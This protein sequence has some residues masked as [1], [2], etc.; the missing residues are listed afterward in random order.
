MRDPEDIRFV[1]ANRLMATGAMVGKDR[2]VGRVTWAK[3]TLSQVNAQK[4]GVGVLRWI[5][6]L[7]AHEVDMGNNI[8]S[9]DID[10]SIGQD[11]ATCTIKVAN[12][13]GTTSQPEGLDTLGRPGFLTP[14][15]GESI[16]NYT[17]IFNSYLNNVAGGDITQE[18][19]NPYPTDWGYS[20]NMYRD[21]FIPNTVIRTYQGYGSDNFDEDGNEKYVHDPAS[22]GWVHPKND[23][24]LYLTGVWLIDKATFD[25]QGNMTLECRDLGKLLIEQ[26]IYPPMI[27]ISRYPLI[28]CPA[29]GASGQHESIGRNVA[30]YHS[31]SVD[32]WYG[33]NAAVFGHRGTDAFDGSPGSFWLSVGNGSPNDYY[34]YEWVQASTSGK[35]NE[36]VLNCKGNNYLIYVSVYEN[37]A[38]QG[39][40]TI[41]YQPRPPGFPNQ[42]NIKFVKQVTTGSKEKITIPLPRTYKA[43]FVRVTFTNLQDLGF[44]GYPYRAGLRDFVVRNHVGNTYKP[45]APDGSVGKEGIRYI[46]DWSEPIKELCAW[47]G[48]TWRDATPNAPDPLFGRSTAGK[49]LQVWG[50]FEDIGAGPIVCTPGTYFTAK[51]FMQGIRQIVDFIGGIFFVDEYGGANFRLPNIWTGGN[52]ITDPQSHFLD[53]AIDGHPIEFHENA[54]LLEYQLVLDDSQ[55]RSEVLV[56]GG[57]P[58]VHANGP[59][60]GGTVLGFNSASNQTSSIDFTDVL[61]GQTRLFAVPPDASALFFTE[62]ECQRMAELI[63]LFIL[64]SYRKGQLKAPCHPGLQ[65]DDQIRIFER[66]TYEHYIHYVSGL[67]T[68]MNLATGEYVMDVTC[69]WLG[70]DPNTVWFVDKAQLTPAVLNLPAVAKRT[71]REANSDNFEKPPYGT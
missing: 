65:I 48:F 22:V 61:A 13:W 53:A 42:S 66:Q 40:D 15:R 57:Y 19:E 20:K 10:R 3:E 64:F 1:T 9:I 21:A 31:S 49:P 23:T 17:S 56:V 67:R 12:M 60:A 51:S 7:N 47:A 32:P 6:L 46:S 45:G 58:S 11:A 5:E 71:G 52:Y 69:H 63:S 35:V 16:P 14:G 29:Y 59:I 50:D 18:A 55:V 39:T 44:S 68:S 38:W 27:P 54:N 26:Y 70:K 8:I 41:P 25:T 30:R 62:R 33:K 34:S 36:V 4:A 28:Y 24:K 37:G 2:A 43:S